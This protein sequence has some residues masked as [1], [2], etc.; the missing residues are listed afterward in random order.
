[1]AVRRQRLR[2]RG[3]PKLT[4]RKLDRAPPLSDGGVCP[5]S[6][7]LRRMK[8]AMQ[9]LADTASVADAGLDILGGGWNITERGA[10]RDHACAELEVRLAQPRVPRE[11][12]AATRRGG[13]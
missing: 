2:G 7:M 5:R 10:W 3:R 4:L 13:A 12:I 1:M 9:Q 11:G 6:A 8:V